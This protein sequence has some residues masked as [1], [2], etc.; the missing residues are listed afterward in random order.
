[1][2]KF[3]I[4]IT[5]V[6][7]L[8]SVV[9]CSD[10]NDSNSLTGVEL[11]EDLFEELDSYLYLIT[12]E[13]RPYIVIGSKEEVMDGELIIDSLQID[14]LNNWDDLSDYDDV[15][16]YLLTIRNDMLPEELI[17]V[18]G[19]EMDVKLTINGVS[20]NGLINVPSFPILAEQELDATKDFTMTWS[21]DDDAREQTVKLQG[22]TSVSGEYTFF[23]VFRQIS[24]KARS[25]TFSKSNYREF[26]E[27]GIDGC[28]YNVSAMNYKI[29]DKHLLLSRADC[30]ISQ[31]LDSRV[32]K[33][34]KK[35]RELVREQ[36]NP[37]NA[38]ELRE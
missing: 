4:M 5:L 14:I 16:P 12:D 2:R 8:M 13:E 24:G 20:H 10:G 6:F 36:L 35:A 23:D 18:P 30:Y 21:L 11:T 15:F 3:I 31:G 7:I 32:E 28:F 9:S 17:I 27:T 33:K 25:Y 37:N 29:S 1:M 26:V 22:W 34:F 19:K 38:V